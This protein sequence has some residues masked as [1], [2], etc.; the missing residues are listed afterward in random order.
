[1]RETRIIEAQSE[2]EYTAGRTL[3]EEYASTLGID[4]HFQNFDE[5]LEK[6]ENLYGPPDGCL[7]LASQGT[8]YVGC[9][10]L[11][12]HDTTTCEMKRLYVRPGARGSGIG[13]L[14]ASAIIERATQLHYIRMVLDTLPTMTAAQS[15]YLSPGFRQIESYYT[16]PIKGTRFMA[17]DIAQSKHK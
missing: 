7:L 12:R 13:R 5:E 16:N 11:R 9:V 17:L 14:L 4:L 2:S 6:L 8:Q 3:V 10:A 15:L 1:M